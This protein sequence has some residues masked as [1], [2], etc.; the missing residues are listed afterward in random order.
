MV[1]LQAVDETVGALVADDDAGRRVED[2]HLALA[3]HRVAH[4]LGDVHGA[5]VVVHLDVRGVRLGGVDVERDDR[6]AG[7][8]GLGDRRRERHRVDRLQE[9]HRG[10][11]V[12]QGVHQARLHLDLVL[13]VEQLVVDDLLRL[14]HFLDAL[15]PRGGHGVRLPLDEGHLVARSLSPRPGD[16]QFSCGGIELSEQASRGTG[17]CSGAK[18]GSLEKVPPLVSFFAL[19]SHLVVLPVSGLIFFCH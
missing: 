12:D 3:A 2:R 13:A 11:L 9:D 1:L 17:Q 18:Y 15:R 6:D 7:A 10:A 19:Q 16:A 14:Q 8:L 4:R 5:E